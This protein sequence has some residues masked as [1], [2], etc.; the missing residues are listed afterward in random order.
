MLKLLSAIGGPRLRGNAIVASRP[1]N[2]RLATW[3]GHLGMPILSALQERK[4]S[5]LVN[6]TS[7]W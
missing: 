4:D 7:A 6:S 3:A 5:W 1:G 2:Y